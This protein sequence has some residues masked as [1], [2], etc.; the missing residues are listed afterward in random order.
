MNFEILSAAGW[1]ALLIIAVPF[2]IILVNEVLERHGAERP[3]MA[4]LLRIAR[5]LVLPFLVL[6]L[7]L[8]LIFK[9]DDS[10]TLANI[11]STVFWVLLAFLIYRGSMMLIGRDEYDSDDWRANSPQLFLR[12][13]PITI[14]GFILYHISQNLWALPVREL[15]TTLGIGSIV[16]AFALQATLSNLV[17]GLLMLAK[18]PFKTGDWVRFDDIEGQIVG[19]NWRYTEMVD[20]LGN[21]VV[22]PNG[23]IADGSIYNFSRP[24]NVTQLSHEFKFAFDTP[25]NVVKAL[26]ETTLFKTPKVLTK[27]KPDVFLLEIENPL[28]TYEVEFWIDDFEVWE[29]IKSDFLTRLWYAAQREKIEFPL[30]GQQVKAQWHAVEDSERTAQSDQIR[31]LF[32]QMPGFS[33]LSNDTRQ[34]LV[35]C[36]KSLKFAKAERILD[37]GEP[38]GGIHLLAEGEVTLEVQDASGQAV[39]LSKIKSGGFFG[40]NGLF[41]RPISQANATALSDCEIILITHSDFNDILDHEPILSDSINA[42]INQRSHATR[43]LGSLSPAKSLTRAGNDVS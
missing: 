6:L 31:M 32:A 28:S 10:N 12:L 23:A 22:F 43:R 40:E 14:I 42:V 19:V 11:A 1:G 20:V 16:I 29:E 25:P 2:M 13:V 15:L 24:S 41:G 3:R 21:L 30:P 8:R 7:V 37:T 39:L 33:S 18:S 35:A 38:E 9:V 26:I 17:S 27:P 5:D 36:S 4:S 34:R